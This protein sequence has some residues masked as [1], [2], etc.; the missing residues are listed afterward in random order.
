MGKGPCGSF[1]TAPEG[2]V[3]SGEQWGWCEQPETPSWAE[4]SWHGLPRRAVSISRALC[5]EPGPVLLPLAREY[6]WSPELQAAHER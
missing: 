5:C 2:M 3:L 6:L 4:L 1:V